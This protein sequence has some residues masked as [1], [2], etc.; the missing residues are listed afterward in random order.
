MLPVF[1][2]KEQVCLCSGAVL[3]SLLR[4]ACI[5][6][7]VFP[8]SLSH[9][10]THTHKRTHFVTDPPK[11][12]RHGNQLKTPLPVKVKPD[13][14]L[15]QLDYLTFSDPDFHWFQSLVLEK[16]LYPMH[17]K[18]IITSPVDYISRYFFTSLCAYLSMFS[19]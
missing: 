8:L 15:V 12:C 10:H 19:S 6:Q 4:Q 16:T 2:G 3:R 5:P 1:V 7:A 13:R 9:V 17:K 14:R 11:A 18:H